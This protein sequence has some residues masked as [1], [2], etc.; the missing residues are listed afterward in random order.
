[1]SQSLKAP[2]ANEETNQWALITGGSGRGGAAM[3]RALHA[4]GLSVVIHHTPR[5]LAAATALQAELERTRA[6]TTQLW[7]ADFAVDD[8]AVPSWLARQGIVVLICN[9]SAYY[10]SG[11]DN[12]DRAHI[13]IA[14]HITAHAAILSA[15][16]PSSDPLAPPP[17]LRS[18]VVISDIAVDRPP[19]GHVSYTT[20]KGALQSMALA[21]ASDW[22]PYVRFNVVQAGT[23]P[24]PDSWTDAERAKRIGASIPLGRL[25]TFEDL[26]GAVV[27]L[28]LDATYVTGQVLAV[29]GGRSR[30]LD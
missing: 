18:V 10:P 26:A 8:F 17:M 1:L 23:L 5:S 25:G 15:L 29:D 13:D 20:A 27:Y 4:R 7:S 16:R 30:R 21:L 12:I 6:G 14:I 3:V 28:A 11:I 9:A 19:K 2:A 24:Y 22:A